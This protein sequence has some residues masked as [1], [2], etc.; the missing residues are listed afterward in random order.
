MMRKVIS[1][2]TKLQVF[3]YHLRILEDGSASYTTPIG[4][5][6][7]RVMELIRLVEEQHRLGVLTKRTL[8]HWGSS[9]FFVFGRFRLYRANFVHVLPSCF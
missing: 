6:A 5:F 1:R 2:I 3:D 4:K 9:R 7:R 8:T